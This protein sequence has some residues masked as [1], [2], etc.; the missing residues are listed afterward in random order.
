[1]RVIPYGVVVSILD[2]NTIGNLQTTIQ[3]VVL[4]MEEQDLIFYKRTYK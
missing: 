4:A 3:P 2:P 1:V